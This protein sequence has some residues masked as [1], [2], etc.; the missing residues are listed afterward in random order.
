MNKAEQILAQAQVAASD[1]AAIELISQ[2]I[3]DPE[4]SQFTSLLQAPAVSKV[5]DV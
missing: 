2:A 1:D 3:D 4:F 5:H